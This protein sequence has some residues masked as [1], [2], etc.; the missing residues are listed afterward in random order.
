[1]C[2][3][4]RC[5]ENTFGILSVRWRILLKSIETSHECADKIVKAACA[6]HNFLIV[7]E[8]PPPPSLVDQGVALEKNGGWRQIGELVQAPNIRVRGA[9]NSK[10]EA[11]AIRNELKDYFCNEGH[12]SWQEEMSML[13]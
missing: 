3:A 8:G 12:V 13:V 11:Q 1:L 10:T 9:N 2:R 6:L 7:E 5:I 4:R